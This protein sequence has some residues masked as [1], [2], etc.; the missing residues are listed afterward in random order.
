MKILLLAV[1]ALAVPMA[2]FAGSSIDYTNSGGTL[3]VSNSGL[4]LTSSTWSLSMGS[5]EGR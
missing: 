2:V 4:T 5:T 3:A 1:L